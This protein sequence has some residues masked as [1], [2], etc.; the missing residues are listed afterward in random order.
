MERGFFVCELNGILEV[1]LGAHAWHLVWEIGV[2]TQI[3]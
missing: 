3:C 1:P 2:Y